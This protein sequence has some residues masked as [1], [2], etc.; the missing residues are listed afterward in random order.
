MLKEIDITQDIIKRMA[1]NSF[2]IKGWT[3]TPVV[4]TLLF[5]GN[6]MQVFIA[7][8]PL[9]VFLFLDAYFLWQ[10]R[11]YRELYN[12]VTDKGF[13]NIGNWIEEAAKN[14]GK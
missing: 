8:I 10:E 14:A 3:I 9:I 1:S 11:L 12:W 2:M 5:K 7:F 13:N 4:A 6:K